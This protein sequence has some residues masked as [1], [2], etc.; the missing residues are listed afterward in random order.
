MIQINDLRNGNWVLFK[1]NRMDE[2]EFKKVF[3]I[4]PD[5]VSLENGKGNPCDKHLVYPIR[6][7]ELIISKSKF[8]EIGRMIYTI[9]LGSIKIT[10]EYIN[11]RG[12]CLTVNY[13]LLNTS[14]TPIKCGIIDL[15]RL[16]NLYFELT[17]K[18][19]DIDL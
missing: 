15:H 11:L 7:T 1:K 2:G 8:E 10:L 17:D 9:D 12:W 5:G 14:N 6:L 13:P 19:L 3:A 4:N 18:E 16:Q